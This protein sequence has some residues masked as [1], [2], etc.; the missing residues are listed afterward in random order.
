M[1]E[2]PSGM[3]T[4]LFTDLEGSTRMWEEHPDAMRDAL[5]RHDAILRKAIDARDGVIVKS[6]GD[7]VYAVFTEAIDAVAAAADAVRAFSSEAWGETGPL[8]ARIGIHTGSAEQR[9]GDYFGPALNRASRLMTAAHGGQ[10][11]LS[12]VSAQLVREVLPEGLALL[13]L[14]EHRLRGLMSLERVHELAIAGVPSE[15]PPLQSLDAFPGDLV[16]PGP[17]F[18]LDDEQL[19]GRAIELERLERAW[20]HAA[21]GVRQIA[22]VGGEPGIGKTRL[23]NELSRRVYAQRGAVLYGRCDEEAI[24]PYQPFV[25]ALRPCINAYAPSVLRE[26]LHGLESDLARVFPELLGRVLEPSL[27]ISGDAEAERYRFFEAITT[28]VTGITATQPMLL[29][30]DDL[31]WA[32]KPT[33]LL[34]RHLIRYAPRASLMIL[35]CYR[36]IDLEGG[37]PFSDLLADLRREP[38]VARVTLAGLSAEESGDFLMD[39]AGHEVGRA[40]VTALHRETDGNPFFLEELLRH[41]METDGLSRIETPGAQQVDLGELDLPA[42]VREVVERRLRRLPTSVNDVLA[43]AAVIGREFDVALLAR[44][45]EQ[46]TAYVLEALDEATDAGIVRHDPVRMGRYTFSHA[47][48][49]QTLNAAR[50][51]ARRARLHARAG[52]AMEESGDAPYSA[53][54]LA[55]HFTHAVP[56]VGASKAIEYTTQAGHDALADLAFEDAVAH[57]ERALELVEQYAPTDTGRAWSCSRN[58]RARSCMSMN[59]QAWRRRCAPSTPPGPTVHLRSSG[60]RSP[61]SSS[62]STALLH[63]PRRSRDCST[64]RGWCSATAIGRCE[65][66]CWRSKRSSTQPTNSMGET[67]EHSPNKRSRSHA[68]APIR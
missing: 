1:S 18:A 56:L 6:T 38:D 39:R 12:H 42:S 40:L 16:L 52:T 13:D 48:I 14:G 25:E 47:L 34:L 17:S 45:A 58:S 46:P 37:D 19:A 21:T 8:R 33:L 54:Q 2:L 4:F 57:F 9:D 23:A 64:T 26:R 5:A 20:G 22:L 30:L 59:C 65:L 3:V 67:P 66:G 43:F 27:L 63:S 68:K 31:H 15:F 24:V 55:L 50:G 35:A 36:N 10:V 29:V 49:R 41:L 61:C 28:L 44:A 51:R 62:P 32:D 11:V 53:A 60:A 7:G